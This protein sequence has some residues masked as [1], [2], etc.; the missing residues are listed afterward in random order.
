LFENAIRENQRNNSDGF[1][2]IYAGAAYLVSRYWERA[3]EFN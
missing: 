3:A 2:L 1:D